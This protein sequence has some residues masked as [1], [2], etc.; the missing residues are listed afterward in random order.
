MSKKTDSVSKQADRAIARFN[1]QAQFHYST[2]AE[3]RLAI[4]TLR[5]M[6]LER[7]QVRASKRYPKAKNA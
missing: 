2:D 4:A 1:F 3:I 6:L 5:E 7:Q